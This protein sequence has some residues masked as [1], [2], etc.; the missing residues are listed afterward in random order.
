MFFA[1][2][3]G[4]QVVVSISTCR[5][6]PLRVDYVRRQSIVLQVHCR[7]RH[8]YNTYYEL[9][10]S[11]QTRETASGPRAPRCL[12]LSIR[13]LPYQH[14][15]HRMEKQQLADTLRGQLAKA[16][17]RLR[18]L[19]I[20][21]ERLQLREEEC[22]A[23]PCTCPAMPG[24]PRATR[25]VGR[26]RP[27]SGATTGRPEHGGYREPYARI[28]GGDLSRKDTAAG[29]V[30]INQS[31]SF[32]WPRVLRKEHSFGESGVWREDIYG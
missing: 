29:R 22:N 32:D 7:S 6:T 23:R 19:R 24:P 10:H 31:I 20:Q 12:P 3:F 25:I 1:Q 4:L 30:L 14:Y 9:H 13:R 5:R 18:N 28:G 11:T 26:L 27:R 21:D 2:C 16:H 8:H 15:R 17:I